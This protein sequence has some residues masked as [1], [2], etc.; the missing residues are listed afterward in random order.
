MRLIAAALLLGSAPAIA[1][2]SAMLAAPVSTPV[3]A[4]LAPALVTNVALP[5]APAVEIYYAQRANA[6]IWFRDGASAEAA[7]LLPGMLR[8]APLDGLANGPEL[9]TMVEAALARAASPA[10]TTTATAAAAKLPPHFAEEKLLSVVWVQYVR[11]LKAPVPGIVY[12]DSA[13]EPKQPTAERVLIDANRAPSLLQHV[14]AVAAVNPLYSQLRDA[15]LTQMGGSAQ[16]GALAPD[17]RVVANLARARIIPPSGRYIVV[18]AATAQLWMYDDG[19]VSDTMKVIV[20]KRDTQTPLLAGTIHYVT[21]NPY[22]NI[23]TDV[24]RRAVAP[25]VI[26]RGVSYL[27]EARYQVTTNWTA[28]GA[29]V[30]P[31][32]IDWKAV[33]AGTADVHLRQLP[34]PRNMMGAIKF[35]FANDLGIYLHDTPHKNLFAKDKRNFSLGCVRLEDAK[36]LAQWVL[37]REPV[38]PSDEPE[39]NVQIEQGVPVFI[40]YLTAHS[41]GGQLAFANDVYGRD[42]KA[43]A[44]DD[45]RL[46]A[47]PAPAHRPP[48]IS[49]R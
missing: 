39:Q 30:E 48:A 17:P 10:V 3:S 35:G 14:Q 18:N 5:S 44:V 37:G 16:L 28:G 26:K 31:S 7:K 47:A 32:T 12:G 41:D 23:P 6:P 33:A 42:P 43:E 11:N 21:F 8:R 38:A 1:Q 24:A 4:P 34:G 9:A 40:T 27:R 22:W 49:P 15:A 29:L 25:L 20:G 2:Q 19:R 36:R 45:V 46:A 13:L